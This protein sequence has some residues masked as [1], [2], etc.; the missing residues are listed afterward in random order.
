MKG[1][2]LTK[3]LFPSYLFVL[4]NFNEPSQH[5]L[6]RYTRGVRHILG[7][8]EGP[9]PISQVIVK[10]LQERAKDGPLSEQ[11]LLLKD[12]DEVRVR[13]GILR[14]LDGIIEKNI[15][16]QGRVRVLFKWLNSTMRAVLKYTDLE[17]VA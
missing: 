17:K 6:V 13:R 3:P 14:D 10:T 9:Q 15:P 2:C 4:A 8:Q 12:G 11:A 7:N 1:V 5:R 16:A